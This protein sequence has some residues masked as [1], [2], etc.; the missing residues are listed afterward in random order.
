MSK[1]FLTLAA[2][3]MLAASAF[4]VPAKRVKR[5]VQQPDGSLSQRRDGG[6]YYSFA[7][8]DIEMMLPSNPG[9]IGVFDSGYGGLT[10]LHGY[11]KAVPS[12]AKEW[13]HNEDSS[14]W[15]FNL[16]DDVD[17]V[18]AQEGSG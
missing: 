7:G 2:M 8:G 13:S 14:V 12:V 10:I 9:P 1:R 15:T 18:T 3:F 11:G 17:W 16:R 5:Q 4:A 6:G